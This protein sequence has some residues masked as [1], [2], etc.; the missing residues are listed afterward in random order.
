MGLLG[1]CTSQP[2]TLYTVFCTSDILVFL[3]SIMH[4]SPCSTTKDE[5]V[6]QHAVASKSE[7]QP[8]R[9]EQSRETF[10]NVVTAVLEEFLITRKSHVAAVVGGQAGTSPVCPLT[11][12]ESFRRRHCLAHNTSQH[13]NLRLFYLVYSV[14]NQSFVYYASMIIIFLHTFLKKIC[15]TS[16][17]L[18]FFSSSR[19]FI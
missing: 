10:T 16:V 7:R 8:D 5:W 2:H 19:L 12:S 4:I 17:F 6:S 3:F 14:F 1:A 11:P 9:N 18:H 15:E 13:I